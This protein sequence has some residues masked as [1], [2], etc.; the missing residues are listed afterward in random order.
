FEVKGTFGGYY[1]FSEMNTAM[2]DLVT[3]YPTLVQKTS[4]GTTIGGRSIWCIKISDNA[5][6]DEANEPEVLIMGLQHAREAIGGS[7]MIFL[8]QYLCENYATDTRIKDLVDNR[9]IFIIVCVNPDGW[10]HNYTLNSN[11]GGL[12]RKNRRNNGGGDYGVDLNRNWGVD[13]ANCSAPIVGPSSSCGSSDPGSDTYW[14]T[15]AFSEAET[16]AIRNFTYTRNFVSMIDQHSYG[17]YYSIPFGRPSL[18]SNVMNPLD[19]KFYDYMCAA[20]GNYNGMRAG[21]TPQAL[22]YETAGGVKDWMLKGNIGT[23]SKG[24]VLGMTSE[25]A[26]GTVGGATFWP[27]ASQIIN[28]CKGLTYQNLQLIYSAGSYINLQDKSDINLAVVSGNLEFDATRVGIGSQPV[29]VSVIPLENIESVGA[30]VTIGTASLPNYYDTYSGSIAYN[31]P[32]ALPL[33]QRIKFAW[34]IET[35][36]ITYYDTVIK[37][38]NATQM[39]YDNMDGSYATNWVGT[40]GWGFSS[41]G[42]G[43]SGGSSRAMTESPSGNYTASSTRRSTYNNS[44]DLGNATAAHISFWVRHRA[45]NFRD[46]LQ[47]QVSINSTDG[48]NGTWT[49]IKGTTTVQETGNLD[50]NTLNGNPA[51]TGIKEDWTRELY[52]ISN[53][54]GASNFRFRFEFTSDANTTGFDFEVDDGFY[55]DNLKVIKTTT[56]LVILPVRFVNVSASLTPS[57][58]IQVKWLAETEAKPAYFEVEKSID[59]LT[60]TPIKRTDP[61][62]PCEVID[63]KPVAGNNY[64]RIKMV[65]DDGNALYSRIVN[66][67]YDP[68]FT[69]SLYPN[70]AREKLNVLIKAEKAENVTLKISDLLGRQVFSRRV[71]ASKNGNFETID[72]SG[73]PAQLY[74]LQVINSEHEILHTQ[75]FLKE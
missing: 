43:Y 37:Y 65:Q 63:E 38:Y 42:T 66:V 32:G 46:K 23:G 16:Q 61:S 20:M 9:E 45:E 21:N 10:E 35:G 72:V 13:W 18:A 54:I 53:Y 52:D 39:V 6:T 30:P 59:R 75:K 14:G 33:G 12:W 51:L 27:P 64:Y 24:K 34:K 56:P 2:N 29:T 55:I 11:G 7:S 40:N 22:N 62:E 67:V 71:P 60:F 4:I 8:M 3:A 57:K 41:V 47:L 36:G 25:G 73:W 19:Q 31:L 5:S 50:G 70:P 58:T 69:V 48:V 68:A 15:A 26:T 1:R 28:L 49:P 74:L 44:L 17:P